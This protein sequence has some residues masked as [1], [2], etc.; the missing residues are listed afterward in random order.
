MA[1]EGQPELSDDHGERGPR[2]RRDLSLISWETCAGQTTR[3]G[4]K[5]ETMNSM[6]SCVNDVCGNSPFYN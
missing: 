2:L 5:E 4:I 1:Y 6:K 3:I